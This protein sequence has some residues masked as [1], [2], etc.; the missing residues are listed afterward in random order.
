MA[1]LFDIVVARKL[2]GGGGG[3]SSDFS[4]AE[5]TIINAGT[6]GDVLGYMPICHEAGELGPEAPALIEST[7]GIEPG[8]TEVFVVPIYKNG[9]LDAAFW[10]NINIISVTGDAEWESPNSDVYITGN[11][12]IT[13]EYPQN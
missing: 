10:D 5:V 8:T 13:A 4:T 12:T 2:S 9:M 3:G 6:F 7:F 1:D 11:C